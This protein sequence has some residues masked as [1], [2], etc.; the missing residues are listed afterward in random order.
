MQTRRFLH[1][2]LLAITC[3]AALSYAETYTWTDKQGHKHFGDEI[4]PEYISQGKE[5]DT[6]AINTV[7]AVQPTNVTPSDSNN[8]ATAVKIP[9]SLPKES[10]T[11]T[12]QKRDYLNAQYCFNHCRMVGGGI[13]KA[14]C[15]DCQ[16]VKKPN[17]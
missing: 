3:S 4:P 13:N 5:V 16:D 11:C 12:Q 6:K 1:F 14:K 2:L 10:E 15:A 8:T 17:C 9:N 7:P